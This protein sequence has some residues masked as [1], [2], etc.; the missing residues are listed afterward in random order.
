MWIMFLG[1]NL[2]LLKWCA[3]NDYVNFT[4]PA[5][6]SGNSSES[7][8]NRQITALAAS[9]SGEKIKHI[10]VAYIG[11]TE[12]EIETMSTEGEDDEETFKRNVIIGW[13]NKNSSQGLSRSSF[14]ILLRQ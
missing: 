5:M 10:A 13:A 6:E 11:F 1:H 4:N 3:T 7:L 9:M 2:G 12:E 14:F 8:T